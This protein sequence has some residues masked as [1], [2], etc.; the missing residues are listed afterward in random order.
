MDRSAE[1]RGRESLAR[2]RQSPERCWALLT[3]SWL[4][5]FTALTVILGHVQALVDDA[6]DG[7]DLCSQLL[8]DPFQVEAVIVGDEVDGEAQVSKAPW[9]RTP[10][11]SVVESLQQKKSST[12]IKLHPHRL[13]GSS[14]TMKVRFSQFG[15]VKVD[16][17]IHSLDINSSCE[18]V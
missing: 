15:E 18:K 3:S 14:N 7:F 12:G 13:T 6:W 1:R 17:N 11:V 9:M 8:L 5:F 2:D 4:D 10:E 16:N